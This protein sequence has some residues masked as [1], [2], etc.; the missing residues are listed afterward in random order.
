MVFLTSFTQICH[1]FKVQS[2][3]GDGSSPKVFMRV[4]WVFCGPGKVGSVAEHTEVSGDRKRS[5]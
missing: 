5:Q 3:V 2:C 1:K 4:S